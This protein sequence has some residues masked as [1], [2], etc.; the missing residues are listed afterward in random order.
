MA[1]RFTCINKAGGQHENPYV[2]ISHLSWVE[3]GTGKTG[4][5]T[6]LEIYDWIKDK[7]GVAYVQ[8]GTARAKVITAI[9]SHGTRFVKTQADSTERDNLLKLPECR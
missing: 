8:A 6:R 5:N 4:K 1:I 3:D 7:N 2:A 9:S